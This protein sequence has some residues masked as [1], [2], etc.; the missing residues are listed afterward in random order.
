MQEQSQRHHYMVSKAPT[1]FKQ[2]RKSRQFS[3][4]KLCLLCHLAATPIVQCSTTPHEC[5]QAVARTDWMKGN[6]LFTRKS[7]TCAITPKAS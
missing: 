2:M 3:V 1:V 6:L 4:C 7:P 5:L